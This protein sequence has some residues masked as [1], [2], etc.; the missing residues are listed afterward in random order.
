[1]TAKAMYVNSGLRLFITREDFLQLL[2]TSN[3]F[4]NLYILTHSLDTDGVLISLTFEAREILRQAY[5][6]E[7]TAF[8]QAA[9]DHR[10][11]PPAKRPTKKRRKHA[12]TNAGVPDPADHLPEVQG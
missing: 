1:M 2:E 9:V 4:C 10:M 6:A 12:K 11:H 5:M 3:K 7:R 8:A